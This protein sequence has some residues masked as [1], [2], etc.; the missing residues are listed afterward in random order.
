MHISLIMNI[1][2]INISFMHIEYFSYNENFCNKYFRFYILNILGI[3]I[4]V[5]PIAYFSNN[6]YFGNEY[7]SNAYGIFH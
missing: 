2:V 1:L 3:N 5:M 4:S 6:E 7:F